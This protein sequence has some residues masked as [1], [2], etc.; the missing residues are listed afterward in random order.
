[1]ALIDDAFRRAG[2]Y[3]VRTEQLLAEESN[4]KVP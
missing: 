2:A 3:A 1:L 4:L